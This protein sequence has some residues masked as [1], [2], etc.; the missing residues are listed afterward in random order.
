[1]LVGDGLCLREIRREDF[2]ELSTVAPSAAYYGLVGENPSE[3]L[4]FN[5]ELFAQAFEQMLQSRYLW[6]IVRDG[7]IIG[8]ALLHQFDERGKKA[9]F[10]IG[11]FHEKNWGRGF[12]TEAARLVIDFASEV[13]GLKDLEVRVLE[14]NTRAISCY[15]KLGFSMAGPLDSGFQD[16]D[17]W[18]RDMIMKLALPG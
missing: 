15:R 13:L 8:T 16:G 11:I 6:C 4:F 5:S 3:S 7:R 1:M 10:A 9:R 14:N 12:G 18:V 17:K 2:D